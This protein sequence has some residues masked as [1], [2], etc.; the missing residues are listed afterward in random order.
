MQNTI[1][2]LQSPLWAYRLVH[3]FLAGAALQA[4][5][6]LYLYFFTDQSITAEG[7]RRALGWA[8]GSPNNL[9]L[10]L[11]RAWPILLA[12]TL[13][14]GIATRQRWLYGAGLVVVSLALFLTFSKGALFLGLPA[15]LL[16]MGW[17]LLASR[18]L[19]GWPWPRL[20]LIASAAL[21]V[22]AVALVPL[23]QTE[24]FRTT[25][26]FNQGST[27]FFRVKLWQASLSM[28][29][30]HW[31]LGVG[32]D[33]F[34][35]QYRTRYILPEAWQEPN[36]SHPH[37]LIL[38]F[39]TRLGLG[40][41]I[42]LLWLQIAFWRSALRL[43]YR[44]PHPLVLGLLGSMAV[45]LAHGLVDNSYFLVDLAFVFFLTLGMIQEMVEN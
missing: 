21:V 11:D 19:L 37:N 33:N 38:D 27:G 34:L 9:A 35:Y 18:K 17:L 8:Y 14:P 4:V 31:L 16:L 44:S 1:S 5:I 39:G 23:S 24:R 6:A 15:G 28:L 22:L 7:V 32:L 29:R 12:L 41:I 42:I 20:A 3:A 36:L 26:D 45:F 30:E 25:F 10:F 40:G 2:N 43:Y 13:W